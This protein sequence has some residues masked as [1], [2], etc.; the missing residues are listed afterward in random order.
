MILT[1]NCICN[2]RLKA[3]H[4]SNFSWSDDVI[5]KAIGY[6]FKVQYFKFT[7]GEFGG[8]K[9]FQLL[10]YKLTIVTNQSGIVR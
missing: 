7:E 10:G 6:S 8:R 4:E 2:L 5:N 1:E 3:F 9:E